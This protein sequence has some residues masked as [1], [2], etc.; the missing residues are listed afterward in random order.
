MN[1]LEFKRHLQTKLDNLLKLKVEERPPDF[2]GQ[3]ELLASAIK[4]MTYGTGP[5]R[6]KFRRNYERRLGS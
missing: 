4:I 2:I 3:K 1:N 6:R 5:E